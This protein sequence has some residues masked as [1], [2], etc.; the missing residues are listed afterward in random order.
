MRTRLSRFFPLLF[1]SPESQWEFVVY[2]S[3][4]HMQ[5]FHL[6]L[7]MLFGGWVRVQF[8]DLQTMEH[9]DKCFDLGQV[10][11]HTLEDIE[12]WITYALEQVG[13]VHWMHPD[14][15]VFRVHQIL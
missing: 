15:T 2:G 9:Q 3:G 10:P 8:V 1:R 7:E 12:E 5:R 13:V 6:S 14:Q 11:L 4:M